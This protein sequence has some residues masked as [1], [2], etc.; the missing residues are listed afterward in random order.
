MP[1]SIEFLE[2]F[3]KLMLTISYDFFESYLIVD[4]NI[5]TII[6]IIIGLL[7]CIYAYP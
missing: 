3:F 6:I 1:H 2:L 7:A 4:I 5:N